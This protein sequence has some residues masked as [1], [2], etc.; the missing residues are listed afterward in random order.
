MQNGFEHD[1]PYS[2]G[3]DQIEGYVNAVACEKTCKGMFLYAWFVFED[4]DGEDLKLGNLKAF[5][6]HLPTG[7]AGY[8]DKR[9]R[10]MGF[11]DDGEKRDWYRLRA[12]LVL[13]IVVA[14]REPPPLSVIRAAA[15]DECG[16]E[17]VLRVMTAFLKIDRWE[18]NEA[19]YTVVHQSFTDFITNDTVSSKSEPF[20]VT[21]SNTRSPPPPPADVRG[22]QGRRAQGHRERV[23]RARQGACWEGARDRGVLEDARGVARVGAR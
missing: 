13:Q 18:N 16:V 23:H 19:H 4:I 6:K 21:G 22:Q 7:L 11:G 12:R 3:N 8:Y 10:E 5:E 15:P 1:V 2:L 9:F 14:A 17:D 20:L